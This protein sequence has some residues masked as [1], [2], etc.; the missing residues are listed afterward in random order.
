VKNTSYK[1]DTKINRKEN[2][3]HLHVLL[4]WN[5]RRIL[6][7]KKPKNKINIRCIHAK[8]FLCI[9]YW[10]S[11]GYNGYGWTIL[12][13]IQVGHQWPLLTLLSI[14]CGQRGDFVQAINCSSILT[15][16]SVLYQH[17]NFYLFYFLIVKYS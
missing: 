9:I 1:S 4:M 2:L 17:I 13:C 10:N 6:Y 15:S 3:I 8:F 7:K 11:F 16:A 12:P 5:I 14:N